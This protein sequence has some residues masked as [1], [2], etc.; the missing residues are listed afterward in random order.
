MLLKNNDRG[1]FEER[2][3]NEDYISNHSVW[4]FFQRHHAE[5]KDL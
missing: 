4:F 3:R 5:L 1:K 2:I